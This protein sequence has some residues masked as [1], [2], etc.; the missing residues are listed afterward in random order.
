MAL[1]RAAHLHGSYDVRPSGD[2]IFYNR[3]SGNFDPVYVEQAILMRNAPYEV[4][5]ASPISECWLH[6][7]CKIIPPVFGF[8]EGVMWGLYTPDGDPIVELRGQHFNLT[9]AIYPG[10][11]RTDV[12]G[13]VAYPSGLVTFDLHAKLVDT[14][15]SE[16]E[17]YRNGG[18]VFSISDSYVFPDYVMDTA[19]IVC[20]G[21]SGTVSQVIMA[22]EPTLGWKVATVSRSTIANFAT[23]RDWASVPNQGGFAMSSNLFARDRYDENAF[24]SSTQSGAR[25]NTRQNFTMPASG[26]QK[27]AGLVIAATAEISAGGDV[28]AIAPTIEVNGVLSILND[29]GFVRDGQ[30]DMKSIT[31]LTNP[32][33]GGVWSAADIDDAFIGVIAL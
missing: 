25:V 13:P 24:L 4:R 10:G 21:P 7:D 26:P 23:Q 31:S 11:S 29:F 3:D 18:S 9:L 8:P 6:L 28:G 20:G 19:K 27:V 16:F 33:T 32:N 15:L 5:L 2:V 12:F 1:L 22:D 17:L 14:G 30:I